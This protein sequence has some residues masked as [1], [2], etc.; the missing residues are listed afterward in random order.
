METAAGGPGRAPANPIV[1]VPPRRAWP[2]G[3]GGPIP[4]TPTLAGRVRAGTLPPDVLAD[5][6]LE[7]GERRADRVAKRS[8][9]MLQALLGFRIP[10]RIP[11]GGEG[12]IQLIDG[13]LERVVHRLSLLGR[14][15]ARIAGEPPV[16]LAELPSHLGEVPADL[17][18]RLARL[19]LSVAWLVCHGAPLCS[20]DGAP[21]VSQIAEDDG[22][23]QRLARRGSG[24][25]RTKPW[26][27]PWTTRMRRVGSPARRGSD[28][29]SSPGGAISVAPGR[30]GCSSISAAPSRTLTSPP[31]PRPSSRLT[32]VPASSRASV[33]S[34]M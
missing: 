9:R 33:N 25:P 24:W 17:I 6:V 22:R 7:V 30:S 21:S 23:D 28:L 29:G 27:G 2:T 11:D 34:R 18:P 15:G 31:S 32:A 16:V 20:S 26:P 1:P 14:G 4:R 8:S 19:L 13:L 3:E 5:L 10:Q 12:L